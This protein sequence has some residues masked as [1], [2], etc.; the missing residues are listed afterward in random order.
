MSVKLPQVTKPPDTHQNIDAAPP[1]V[2][3]G[4]ARLG[5]GSDKDHHH[6][7]LQDVLQGHAEAIQ[8]FS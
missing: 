7:R 3:S 5:E 6:H 8:L 1:A 4:A 2:G